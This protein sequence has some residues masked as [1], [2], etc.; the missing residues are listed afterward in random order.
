MW[1]NLNNAECDKIMNLPIKRVNQN[2]DDDCN[3]DRD[4]DDATKIMMTIIIITAIIE[5]YRK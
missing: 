1:E 2:T 4:V 3:N 5:Y